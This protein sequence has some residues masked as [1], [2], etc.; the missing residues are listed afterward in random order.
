[1]KRLS[2][3]A[4]IG[5]TALTLLL[6]VACT[7]TE[8]V[9]QMPAGTEVT[10]K[11]ADGTLVRG[12]IAKVDS[13]V[14]MLNERPNTTTEIPRESISEVTRVEVAASERR[15][16]AARTE[17]R[18]RAEAPAR[19]EAP[20]RRERPTTIV[21]NITI[22]DNTVLDV[23]LNTALAS[24]TSRVE[25]NVSGTVASPVVIDGLTVIPAGSALR[26][27]VTHVDDSDKVKGRA[28]LGFRFTTLTVSSV[29][30]DID[31]KPLS[32]VA[33]GTKKDDA[34]KIGVGAGVGSVIG[35]ITGGKK[36]AAIGAAVGAGAGTGVVLATDG[37]EIRLAEGRKLKVSLTNPLTIRTK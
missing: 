11:T 19:T 33:E 4:T 9:D 22:P 32:Y 6:T 29:T 13:D 23:T 27:H 31:S 7:R 3:A 36:G 12:T 10:V 24:D 2:I 1:M 16:P 30:Y 20:V 17:P 25:Q 8:P 35:A 28:E 14:V 18:E 5:K 15:A 37:K 34:V 26:G 21:R